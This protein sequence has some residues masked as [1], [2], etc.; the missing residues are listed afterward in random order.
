MNINPT[1]EET[2]CPACRLTNGRP[3]RA[4]IGKV[5]LMK[6]RCSSCGHEWEIEMAAEPNPLDLFPP[7]VR[8]QRPRQ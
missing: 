7:E 3:F 4:T 6:Y 8:P 2:T 5:C 1:Q